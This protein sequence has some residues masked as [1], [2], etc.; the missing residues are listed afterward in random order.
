MENSILDLALVKMVKD[1][2]EH[3]ESEINDICSRISNTGIFKTLHYVDPSTAFILNQNPNDLYVSF[4]GRSYIFRDFTERYKKIIATLK[5]KVI[6]GC[7]GKAYNKRTV[8]RIGDLI[9]CEH[10]YN[11][12][13]SDYVEI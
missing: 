12:N 5:Q 13:F 1:K 8:Y 9:L 10:C 3:V 4:N 7:C 6:C 2:L 11:E